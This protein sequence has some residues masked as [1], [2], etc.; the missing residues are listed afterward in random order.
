MGERDWVEKVVDG[1]TITDTIYHTIPAFSFTNQFEEEV[2]EKDFSD[3]IYIADFFFTSC[4]TICPV[5]KK[6]MLVVYKSIKDFDDVG[7]LS[8]T[9]DPSHDTPQVLAK[10]AE[11]LGVTGKKWQFVTG[12]KSAIYGI[13][14]KGYFIAANED[15]AAPGGF[16]HSGAFTL[17]DREKRVRGVYDGTDE[18]S[19]KRLIE[20][21]KTLRKEYEKGA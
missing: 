14:Q 7:I 13:A 2:T 8:H 11:D 6:N 10:Y 18:K 3:K 9:I 17:V 15:G 21:I 20:D 12:E 5:M 16:I 19:V 1:K 4:P